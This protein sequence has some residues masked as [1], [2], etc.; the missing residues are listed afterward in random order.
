MK[1]THRFYFEDSKKSDRIPS[2]SIDLVVTSPPYPMIK[3]WDDLF[4]EQDPKIQK[5]MD[6]NDGLLSFELMNQMLDRVWDE[7]HRILKFGG[8]ACINIGDAVRTI[9]DNFMLYP[10]HARVISGM[11]SKGFTPLPAIIWRKQTNAPNK[12]MGSGMLPA[13]A[14][15]TLEH[16][17]ILIFRKGEKRTFNSEAEKTSRRNSA[18]FWEERNNWFSDVWMDLKGTVQKLKDTKIRERS[19]AFPFE[20]PYRLIS[21]FSAKGDTVFDPFFGIGTT[22][23]AA[24]AAGRNSIGFELNANVEDTILSRMKTA[25]EFSNSKIQERLENHIEFIRNRLKAE[26]AMK[27][28]NQHYGF[29]VITMQER[30]LL[31]NNLI[32]LNKTGGHS[33]EADYSDD[34]QVEFIWDSSACPAADNQKLN[35]KRHSPKKSLQKQIQ[36]SLL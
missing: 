4:S 21:M 13:G 28:T 10:N 30:E 5:A 9:N 14:Y 11:L 27:H 22:M 25:V 26:K 12:F 19:A 15:V 7:V 23:L 32:S 31:L 20:V 35:E 34:P 6:R 36:L 24:V 2:N 29:P 8:C 18:I 33:F 17:Y 1:T 3:M 16:E